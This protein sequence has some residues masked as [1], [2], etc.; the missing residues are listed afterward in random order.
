MDRCSAHSE[1]RVC[2]F[3]PMNI[4]RECPCFAAS[5]SAAGYF[6]QLTQRTDQSV[7]RT[8]FGPAVYLSLLK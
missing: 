3:T 4:N 8:E 2:T 6:Y 7:M 5:S 1:A